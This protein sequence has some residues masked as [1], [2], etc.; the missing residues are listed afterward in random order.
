M[1]ILSMNPIAY[2]ILFFDPGDQHHH[3]G[4]NIQS[5][6]AE[7]RLINL[8]TTYGQTRVTVCICC[9]D[10]APVLAALLP[11]PNIASIFLC[12]RHHQIPAAVINFPRPIRQ[13][14]FNNNEHWQVEA[15]AAAVSANQDQNVLLHIQS[16]VRNFLEQDSFPRHGSI[17][18]TSSG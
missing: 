6:R 13:N 18:E 9:E 3:T 4:G 16:I 14:S 10:R 7:G 5:C 15:H 8:L 11:M 17:Q 2:S 1:H 12:T